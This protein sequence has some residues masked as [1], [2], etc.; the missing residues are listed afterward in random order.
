MSV[1]SAATWRQHRH[2]CRRREGHPLRA[3]PAV[4]PGPSSG[5]GGWPGAGA[6]RRA[7]EEQHR[8]RS[9]AAVHRQR[10]SFGDRDRGDAEARHAADETRRVPLRGA[11]HC[12]GVEA[13]PRGAALR[14][15]ALGLRIFHRQV[16]G[17]GG[18]APEAA[19]AVRGAVGLLR[20]AGAGGRSGGSAGRLALV[21]V[22]E[23]RG[24]GRDAG[25]GGG[26][27]E[28][29]VGAA[30]GDQREPLGHGIATQKRHRVADR[31]ARAVL[32]VVRCAARRALSGFRALPVRP[33]RRR[34]PARQRDEA[35]RAGQ[36]RQRRTDPARARPLQFPGPCRT[37]S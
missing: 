20:A 18:E 3:D 11:G 21:A 2:E 9:A 6:Q 16:P 26:P 27:G 29:A 5:V 4:G 32:R 13:V 12:R 7:G 25:P 24:D 10:G 35:G 33:H 23:G 22:R 36:A 37:P 30:R 14:A 31:R 15:L 17:P 19:L 28:G 1:F 8:H 34:E